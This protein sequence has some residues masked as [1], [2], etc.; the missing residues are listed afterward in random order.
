MCHDAAVLVS[1]G[2]ASL[3]HCNDARLTVGQA[4]RAAL[5][6]GG[7]LDV[8]AVQMASATWHPI[9]YDYP[10]EQI[11][12]ISAAKRAGK[13]R[14]VS[15]LI[16]LVKPELVVPFA[17]PMCF[18]DPEIQQ[19]NRWLK[20]PGLFPD[21]KQ[22]AEFLSARLPGQKVGLWLP[23]DEYE[24]LS[25]DATSP[26]HTGT[27]S[28]SATPMSTWTRTPAPAAA[29]SRRSVPPSR[30]QARICGMRSSSISGGWA[31]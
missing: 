7:R 12:E 21:Q 18:L 9:C 14:A 24:P 15:R 23:G 31:R 30:S 20:A 2:G 3:L 5:E 29:T 26:T 13:F 19:H 11:R 25:G 27:T 1:A 6:C 10:P 8:M 17:G 28:T 4:R 16:R 22:A